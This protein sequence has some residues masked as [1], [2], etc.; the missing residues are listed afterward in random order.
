[1]DEKPYVPPAGIAETFAW[2]TVSHMIL[3][4]ILAAGAITMLW[5]GR[6]LRRQ[7][8]QALEDAERTAEERDAES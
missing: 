2:V 4:A 1:M 8:K 6:R 3:I 7:R 5:W